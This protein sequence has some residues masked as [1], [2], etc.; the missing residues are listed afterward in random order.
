MISEQEILELSECEE[1]SEALANTL[2][3]A[4]L[5]YLNRKFPEVEDES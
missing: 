2:A 1:L 3:L 5:N 4:I